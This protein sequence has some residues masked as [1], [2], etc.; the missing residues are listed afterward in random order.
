MF[1]SEVH[2]EEDSLVEVGVVDR[3]IVIKPVPARRWSLTRLLKGIT[4]EN[5]HGELDTGRAIG[6]EVW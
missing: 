6:N 3:K 5:A 4:E 2:L 1:A